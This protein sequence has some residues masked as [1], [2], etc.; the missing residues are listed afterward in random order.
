[1]TV[2][3]GASPGPAPAPP[4]PRPPR[5]CPAPSRRALAPPGSAT[6]LARMEREPR[7]SEAASAAAALFAWVRDSAPGFAQRLGA[8]GPRSS[9][10]RR[11]WLE[12]RL[13]RA[14][15]GSG[16]EA[17][18]LAW[19]GG[20]GGKGSSHGVTEGPAGGGV[21]TRGAAPGNRRPPAQSVGSAEPAARRAPG[22]TACRTRGR[23]ARPAP[24][25][26]GPPASRPRGRVDGGPSPAPPTG[27]SILRT[28]GLRHVA[29]AG[30]RPCVFAAPPL[31]LELA[32]GVGGRAGVGLKRAWRGQRCLDVCLGERR[33]CAQ[34]RVAGMHRS[35]QVLGLVWFFS[36]GIAVKMTCV[37]S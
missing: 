14:E 19:S 30:R 37:I 24:E 34:Q 5:A 35:T 3:T 23:E 21:G 8:P 12:A 7:A 1:M 13:R 4:R 22:K 20:Q 2:G 6:E 17:P 26:V 28:R 36:V 29:G 33:L 15:P 32:G 25:P 18:G 9:G 27:W 16:L 11:G 10:P 31:R